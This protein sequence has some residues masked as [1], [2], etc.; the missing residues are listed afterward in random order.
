[1]TVEKASELLRLRTR[2]GGFYNT[3][4]AKLVSAEMSREPG[5]CFVGGLAIGKDKND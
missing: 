4:S 1:L 3:S 5:D 2:F